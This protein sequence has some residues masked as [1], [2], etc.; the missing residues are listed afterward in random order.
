M[1]VEARVI[2][3]NGQQ[4]VVFP[5]GTEVP[6]ARVQAA[7]AQQRQTA[8]VQDPPRAD[9]PMSVSTGPAYRFG[10]V[11]RGA[12]NEDL[13]AAYDALSNATNV[14]TYDPIMAASRYA[15]SMGTAGLLGAIG[16]GKKVGGYAADALGAGYEALGGDRFAKGGAAEA[17]YRDMG[18]GMQA[19]GVGPEARML[20]VLSSAGAGRAAVDAADLTAREALAYARSVGEGDLAFL[21]GGGVP[22][23]LGAAST[24][25]R[26]LLQAGEE[27]PY[28]MSGSD[29][30]PARSGAVGRQ[31]DPSNFTGY[32]SVK[33]TTH[34]SEW[35]ATGRD[36]GGILGEV[37]AIEPSDI[38]GRKLAFATG[39]KT[40]RARVVDTVNAARLKQ[41]ATQFGGGEFMGNANMELWGSNIEGLKPKVNAFNKLSLDDQNNL[42][43][44]YMPMGDQSGDFAK[45]TSE[46][47]AGMFD[48]M[49]GGNR[50]ILAADAAEID[51][52]LQKKFAGGNFAENMPSV[53]SSNF[54]DWL[55]SLNGSNRSKVLKALDSSSIQSRGMADV[56]AARWATTDPNLV[57]AEQLSVGYR[58]GAPEL[59][60]QMSLLPDH[61]SYSHRIMRREGTPS[62]AMEYDLPWTIGA[63]DLARKQIKVGSPD[64]RAKPKDLKSAMINPKIYQDVDQEWVDTAS[65]YGE[66]LR[67]KGKKQADQYAAGLLSDYWMKL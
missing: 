63:R 67:N 2:D 55:T 36:I 10:D 39:D 59:N 51:R 41:P 61:P 49:Q 19:A 9:A 50:G 12:G 31:K 4:M 21:R 46:T 58:F 60:P 1:A 27:S 37:N 35:E 11:G 6:L 24:R 64:L 26:P 3:R 52:I 56:G 33:A 16:A 29:F 48:T 45:H 43:L 5:D 53:S 66:I 13:S 22:Q 8:D 28:V 17:M 20:E 38:F 54:S 62:L 57:N 18:A 15:G 7:M 40:A 14:G 65:T 30:F 25:A 47:F 23:D 34:P 44:A 42:L 32:S